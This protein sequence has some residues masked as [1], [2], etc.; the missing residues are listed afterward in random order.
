M[1]DRKVLDESPLPIARGYRRFLNASEPRERHDAAYYCFEIYLKYVASIAIAHY[2]GG[3]RRDHGVN[4]VLKG[5]V[6]PS[7]GEWL[8]FL[9]ECIG[10]LREDGQPS[11]A[12]LAIDGLLGRQES[13]WSKVLD[14]YNA[15]RSFLHEKPS[16]KSQVH[17][18]G[19][20]GEV[21]AYRNRVL[22]H[23][24]PLG[25]DHY[26][27]FADLLAAAFLEVLERSSFLT[28]L[29][30]V[31]FDSIQVEGS[32]VACGAIEF[33]GGQPVR[34]AEPHA[35]P[36]GS[37]P[38]RKGSLHVLE[39]GGLPLSLDPLLVAHEEDVY[40]LNE[41]GGSP[42]YLSY[43]TGKRLRTANV[44]KAEEEI[45]ERILGYGV[46]ESKISTIEKDIGAAVTATAE[47]A[48][49]AER[50]LGGYRIVREVGRGAMGIVFEAFQE[51][52][53]RRVAL[54]VLPGT[55]A[56][57][58][59][60]LE[61]FHREARATARIHH[62][63][64][65]PIYEVGES[66]G[67]HYY[68]M[69]FIEGR[70][71]ERVIAEARAERRP[72]KRGDGSSTSD[73]SYIAGAI[74]QLAR[75]A[76]GL[77]KAHQ[78]GLVHRDVKPSNI[79]VDATGAHVLVDFGLVHETGGEALTRSGEMVGTLK[80]MSPEQVSRSKVDA[81]ADVY[82][83]GAVLYEVL[84]LE[85][86]FAGASSSSR[87]PGGGGSDFALQRAILFEEPASPRRLNPRI[88]RDLETIIL[89]ALE[90][91][92]ERRYASAGA[93]AADLRR[94]LRGEPIEAVPPT[95]WTRI[96]RRARRHRRLVGA[97]FLVVVFL[98]LGSV[99]LWRPWAQQAIILGDL[100]RLTFDGGITTDPS[101]SPDGSLLAYAS[102]RS[103]KGSLDIWVQELG[104][105][106]GPRQ[107]TSDPSDEREPAFSPDGQEI[108]FRSERDGGGI[109]V[110]SPS[111]GEERLL[112]KAGRRPLYSP[113]G[114]WVLYWVGELGGW[115]RGSVFVI[116]PRGGESVQLGR[117]LAGARWA[118]WAP[119]G[120][121]VL[122]LGIRA[123]DDR[124]SAAVGT[125]DW[126]VA[127]VA[128]G[129]S[130]ATQASGLLAE[131]GVRITRC[132]PAAWGLAA[133]DSTFFFTCSTAEGEDLWSIEIDPSSLEARGPPRQLTQGP[134]HCVK[135]WVT[136]DGSVFFA[137]ESRS[138]D[139]WSIPLESKEGKATSALINLTHDDAL[140][141]S[142]AISE[143]GKRVVFASNKHGHRQ[144]WLRD[145]E[146]D[147]EKPLTP[148]EWGSANGQVRKG[149]HGYRVA[150]EAPTGLEIL[151]VE[152]GALVN[153][154]REQ[155]Y[156]ECW[157][158]DGKKILCTMSGRVFE[159]DVATGQTTSLLGH[160]MLD[161]WEPRYAPDGVWLAFD[162][163]PKASR[164]SQHIYVAELKDGRVA[165]ERDW[166]RI[167]ETDVWN[168]KPRWSPDG[169]L[170][171]YVSERDGFRC[172]YAQ[173]LD[174]VARRPL[175][176][177]LIEVH[178]FHS[179]R[180]SPL[181]INLAE[182][183]MGV[184]IDRLVINLAEL[185]SNVWTARLG[186][187]GAWR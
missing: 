9:R 136:R 148:P 40:F 152:T 178:H 64:I 48:P 167:T 151:D 65:V 104:A 60:R 71:L 179:A 63:S 34:R 137:N 95:A 171:Y 33:M 54:K 66:A 77:E 106:P 170:L 44:A 97:S 58:P 15:V 32:R 112:V 168:D 109:H 43:S 86:P 145:L 138:L 117:D 90:K 161:I 98:L 42:E 69:E 14:L 3:E 187:P 24:A 129:A 144:L 27:C 23:G 176:E 114:K 159:V 174:P 119:G 185:K 101:L 53:G 47:T 175:A 164:T 93:L 94:C 102:D 141:T 87:L 30:L 4:A 124:N 172:I 149:E 128:G 92:P 16:A 147:T 120:A 134:S 154:T 133:N 35:V 96:V 68:A 143:D 38:P 91:N 29:R 121:H 105:D 76:E 166:I 6:R 103:G 139:I 165:H 49:G 158:P 55:F 186:D 146:S 37:Q 116:P 110:I 162:A 132:M 50:R 83:L 177:G 127:P 122:F 135:P 84:T 1:D 11:A 150:V 125:F 7:T 182:L 22:G 62:P 169:G 5:L 17:L 118:V 108:A 75:L 180:L 36:Y 61:R 156:P 160:P 82:S 181:Y 39:S 25:S 88:S 28:A 99:A 12:V 85:S 126:W 59:R 56:L 67:T 80:Y 183:K 13:R 155:C 73:P 21:V 78:Q 2:L 10:F 46:S 18:E 19:L 173:R 142:P 184:A 81:R 57:D 89:H 79:L 140:D 163:C 74:E 157:S 153:V 8:R 123:Q 115:A 131:K 70:S 31:L 130:R 52:L 100:R 51:S 45:F 41:A 111:G 107:L 20:L 113:D 26:R 72:G